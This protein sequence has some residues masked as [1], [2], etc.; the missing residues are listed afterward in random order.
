MLFHKDRIKNDNVFL[1]PS[2]MAFI[3]ADVYSDIY[4][5]FAKAIEWKWLSVKL[6]ILTWMLSLHL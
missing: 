1:Y 2:K 4:C 3:L 5:N 6:F